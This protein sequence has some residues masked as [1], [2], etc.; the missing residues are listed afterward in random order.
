MRT[1][2]R[3]NYRPRGGR[4]AAEIFL[5]MHGS[6]Y[7]RERAVRCEGMREGPASR[8]GR[9]ESL[10]R[11][12]G[13]ENMRPFGDAPSIAPITHRISE[14]T[15]RETLNAR[16]QFFM[17][18]PRLFLQDRIYSAPRNKLYR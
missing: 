6:V 4:C 7:D 3:A 14:Y 9:C 16:I 5:T 11:E 15:D 18:C 10:A 17:G 2:M 1:E 8:R 12:F 13:M